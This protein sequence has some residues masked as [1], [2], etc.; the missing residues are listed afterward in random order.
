MKTKTLLLSATIGFC[1]IIAG[2][3][4]AQASY[5]ASNNQGVALKA[6][7][8]LRHRFV[9]SIN[10][11]AKLQSV[12]ETLSSYKENCDIRDREQKL[13]DKLAKLSQKQNQ[14]FSQER[15]NKIEEI[16]GQLNKSEFD[17]MVSGFKFLGNLGDTIHIFM[18]N[19]AKFQQAG[20]F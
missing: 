11:N 16:Q 2:E 15:A 9:N 6:V 4:S 5:L 20:E 3:L 8:L 17:Q 13:N 19:P 10:R 12:I 14:E 18:I 1:F 7:N